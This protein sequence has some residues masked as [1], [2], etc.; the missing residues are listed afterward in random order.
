M[1]SL[2][3]ASGSTTWRD[4]RGGD[5]SL[6]LTGDA[7]IPSEQVWL[8]QNLPLAST[9]LKVGHHGSSHS[10]LPE[11]V[12]TVNPALAVIQVGKNNYGH[13]TE[14]VLATLADRQVYRNDL[15]GRVHLYSDGQQMWVE[16]ERGK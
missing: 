10:S 12:D 8:D 14:E 11:F 15:H 16:A 5:F 4:E 3:A 13:P 6:L 2:A 7:G 9:V 1:G